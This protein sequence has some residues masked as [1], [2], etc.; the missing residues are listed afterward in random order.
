M[1]VEDEPRRCIF[2]R[3]MYGHGHDLHHSIH[4]LRK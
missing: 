3:L 2:G 4:I 1:L